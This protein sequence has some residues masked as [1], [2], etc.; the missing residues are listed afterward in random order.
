MQTGDRR[1]SNGSGGAGQF[2]KRPLRLHSST[3]KHGDTVSEVFD[4]CEQ[5]GGE[6]YRNTRI[7][8]GPNE[9]HKGLP[10]KSVDPG[11]GLVEIQEIWLRKQGCGELDPLLLAT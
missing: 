2:V 7:S 10:A 1:K 3:R 8:L 4:I 6:H 11:C 9:V 5:V